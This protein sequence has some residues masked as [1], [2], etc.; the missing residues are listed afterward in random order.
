M[1]YLDNNAT[2]QPTPRVI[3]AMLPY[4]TECYFN[5][6]SST[7]A[8]TGAV[9]PRRDAARAMM[10]LL[11]AEEPGCFIFTSGA[12][13]SNNWVIS[14]VGRANPPGR[15]LIS[16]IE[17]PSVARPA[18]VLRSAGCE[19]AEVPVNAE[20]VVRLDVLEEMLTD[21]VVLVSIMAAS[22]ESGALQPL[23]AI[24]QLVRFRAPQ[25][26]F[27]TD[28]T[29]VVG[30]VAIDLQNKWPQV[31]LLSFSAH[32]YHG[33][34][35]VGGLYIRPGVR[36]SPMLFGGGQEDGLRSGTTNTAG[37]A[38]LASAATEANPSSTMARLAEMRD[39]FESALL[40]AIPDTVIHSCATKRLPNTSCF[41]ISGTV[42][43]DLAD[44]LAAAGVIVGTGS[45]CSA[46]TL[47]PPKAVL[48]TGVSYAIG[49]AA[50]RVS[51]S[52]QSTEAE[53]RSLMAHLER[54]T[55]RK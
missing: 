36:I 34:K 7:A 54:L 23:D 41:S 40:K 48:A 24:G 39:G 12:T 17:H 50:L 4:M 51:L 52:T 18:E 55:G 28:A 14:S 19:I 15:I 29:Q 32:K 16:A 27:H 42:A 49:R 38:G 37:L 43:H 30:K 53:L 25:A 33:P 1:I 31:D 35:G 47:Q 20:G 6:S 45:A 26:V 44:S 5:A 21:D 9:K 8:I 2:T 10:V 13:E 46:G 22:N 11:N 3:E